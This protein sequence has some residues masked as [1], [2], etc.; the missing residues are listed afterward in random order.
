[1]TTSAKDITYPSKSDDEE[2]FVMQPKKIKPLE[3][4]NEIN[5]PNEV[6][7]GYIR[8]VCLRYNVEPELVMSIV[9]HESRYN[10]K[11]KNGDCIGLMQLNRRWH[12]GRAK[13]LG[14][15]DFYDP[16][17][18]ILL[19]VDYLSELLNEYKDPK[20]VLM[21]YNMKHS[22]AL[23]LYKRGKTTKY[24]KSVITMSNSYKKGE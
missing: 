21:L 2:R 20:L 19:G 7:N 12:V 5:D 10:P 17:S 13:K 3:V 1:M 22:T 23:K 18:N 6:I 4:K 15:T 24:V 9:Y 16:Y 14:V 11:A 8:E